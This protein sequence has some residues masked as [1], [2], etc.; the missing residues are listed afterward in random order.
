MEQD[1]A[2]DQDQSKLNEC[3][4][5]HKVKTV[6]DGTNHTHEFIDDYVDEGK[7]HQQCTQCFQG[8]WR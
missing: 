7:Q 4:E 8:R 5:I 6:S 2:K 3:F 1:Q